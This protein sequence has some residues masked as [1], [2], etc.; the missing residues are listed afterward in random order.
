MG[1]PIA[2]WSAL[3]S[4]PRVGIKVGELC[5]GLDQSEVVHKVPGGWQVC[6]LAVHGLFVTVARLNIWA[7][8]S[9]E[10][11]DMEAR[12][13]LTGR[14][15]G[16]IE[17]FGPLDR[18]RVATFRLG[19]TP[20]HRD[21]D[22]EWQDQPTTWLT[23]KSFGRLA[24]NVGASLGKGEPVL[25]QGR[26]RTER[27]TGRDGEERERLVL[28]ADVVGHDLTYGMAAFRKQRFGTS[29]VG[30]SESQ[31]DADPASVDAVSNDNQPGVPIEN[32]APAV[33]DDDQ[34]ELRTLDG[35][36]IDPETGEI[37]A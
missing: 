23:V 1:L 10:G 34:Q 28:H 31:T 26:M 8:A 29:V 37:A 11:A 3:T 19:C 2:W 18:R 32:D 22:G 15:G 25:V 17:V 21:R 20:R 24:W 4:D 36:L 16:P 5:T 14:V 12:V 9:N 35:A 13:F 30:S 6:G 7:T 33:A 27:W